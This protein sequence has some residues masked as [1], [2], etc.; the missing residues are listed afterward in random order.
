MGCSL[1]SPVALAAGESNGRRWLV[2]W[3]FWSDSTMRKFT[4]NQIGPR[5]F[6]LPP[7]CSDVDSPG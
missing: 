2:G 5:Q 3:N 4:G 7:K 1:S 6:E